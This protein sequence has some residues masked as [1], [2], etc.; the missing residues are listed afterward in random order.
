MAYSLELHSINPTTA[1]N[2]GSVGLRLSFTLSGSGF[3]LPG[4]SVNLY[5]AATGGTLVKGL[6]YS[7]TEDPI[8][9]N[10]VSVNFSGVAPGTYYVEMYFRAGGTPRRAITITGS[11]S[12]ANNLKLNAVAIVNNTLNGSNVTKETHN[13]STVYEK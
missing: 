1:A 10:A 6:Y 11:S 8:S 3:S 2:T 5:S 9:G 12:D 13:G 4:F 7:D